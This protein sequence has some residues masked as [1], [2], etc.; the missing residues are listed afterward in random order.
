ML[1]ILLN[2]RVHFNI[3]VLFLVNNW[4]SF[5]WKHF[6][7]FSSF[8]SA[9]I[10]GYNL[11]IKTF[12]PENRF[13]KTENRF[14][15][16]NNYQITLN[17]NK[18]LRYLLFQLIR[19]LVISIDTLFAVWQWTNVGLCLLPLWFFIISLRFK[20]SNFSQTTH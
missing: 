8:Y 10:A 5:I 3:G 11:S 12:W 1:K 19:Y 4:L 13:K 20:L 16:D 14:D 17:Y 18:T 15:L 2:N 6:V 7:S 9:P